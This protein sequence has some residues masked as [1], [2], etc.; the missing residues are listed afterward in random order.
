[1]KVASIIVCHAG[2]RCTRQT[3][4]SRPSRWRSTWVGVH[5]KFIGVQVKE[6]VRVLLEAKAMLQEAESKSQGQQKD[7]S[8]KPDYSQDFFGR[9]AFL[10]VSG[11]L[12]AEAY[13]CALTDVYTFGE[14]TPL[15]AL[16]G[17]RKHC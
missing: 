14:S 10:A 2:L 5:C 16:I 11:Q 1:M 13:A 3:E 7:S 4:Q 15:S 12:N 17:G 8:G 9:N 6:E